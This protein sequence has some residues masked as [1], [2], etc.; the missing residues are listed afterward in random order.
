MV[1][2]RGYGAPSDQT[3]ERGL[4]AASASVGPTGRLTSVAVIVAIAGGVGAARFLRGLVQVVPGEDIT[5]IVNTGDDSQFHGL[6]VS[7]DVDTVVYTVAEAID[8]ERGWGLAAESWTTMEALKRYGPFGAVDWF[9]LGDR[10]LATHLWRTGRLRSGDTLSAVTADLAS[11]WG[12]SMRVLPMSDDPVATFVR[13]PLGEL[14]FQ[15]YFVQ[16]RHN[17]E[18]HEVMLRG[19]EDAKPAP[20]VLDAIKSADAIVVCPSNPLVSIGPVLAVDG[21]RDALIRR[22]DRVVAVSPIVAGAALKGPADRMLTEM[23][24]ETS[25]VGV[26]RL[27]KDIVRTL[28]IDDADKALKADVEQVGIECVVTDTIMSKPGVAASLARVAL[29]AARSGGTS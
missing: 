3:R 21:I 14:A 27:Y 11:A 22:R 13:T 9:N 6:H 19:V 23:G 28:L 1:V 4:V 15:S 29:H 12:L 7:P 26:A 8:P 17:V 5:V 2:P 18:V 25:V 16:H 10:D 24:H 20:G